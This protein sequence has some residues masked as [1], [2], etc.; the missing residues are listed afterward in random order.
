MTLEQTLAVEAFVKVIIYYPGKAR[1][2][3]GAM[4]LKLADEPE[5]ELSESSWQF[6]KELLHTYRAQLPSHIHEKHCPNADCQRKMAAEK[7]L[8]N[9]LVLA[10]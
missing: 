5:S 2:F 8:K 6:V 1:Q 9:Q 4:K 3:Q 10:F 7:Q